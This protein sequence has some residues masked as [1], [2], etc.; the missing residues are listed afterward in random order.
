MSEGADDE[1]PAADVVIV[2]GGTAATN[3]AGARDRPNLVV[4]TDMLINQVFDGSRASGARVTKR[5][6]THDDAV[7]NPQLCVRVVDES[8]MPQ[9]VRITPTPQRPR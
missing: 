7:L 5:D 4:R 3:P 1:W 9:I 8:V 2:D 6:C